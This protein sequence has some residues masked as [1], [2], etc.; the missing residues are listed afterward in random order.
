MAREEK[1]GLSRTSV[2]VLGIIGLSIS[3]SY[4]KDMSKEQIKPQFGDNV[5]IK[6]TAETT[7]AGFAGKQGS[8][9]GETTPSVM[10]VEVIGKLQSDYAIAVMFKDGQEKSAWFSPD[11]LEFVDHG[12]GTEIVIGDYKAVRKSDGTWAETKGGKPVG[13][14]SKKPWWKFW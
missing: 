8:V 7:A 4:G 13:S 2:A 12:A 1:N 14:S 3:L 5:R 9:T 11:L 10:K 6:E